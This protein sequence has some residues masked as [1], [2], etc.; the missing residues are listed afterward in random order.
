[1]KKNKLTEQIIKASRAIRRKQLALKIGRS[2]EQMTLERQLKPIVEPLN[3]LLKTEWSVKQEPKLEENFQKPA[4]KFHSPTKI[5]KSPGKKAQSSP[6]EKQTV[7]AAMNYNP[8]TNDEEDEV[9]VDK[10]FQQFREEY[11]SMIETQPNVVDNFLEQYEVLPRVYVDG[12]LADTTGEYDTTTGPHFDP[13]ENKLK[14]GNAIL[15]IDGKDIVI[16]GIRYKGTPGLYELIFKIQP[17]GYSRSDEQRYQDI[18]KRTSVHHRNYDSKQRVKASRSHKYVHIIKPLT[19][20]SKS[21]TASG[22]KTTGAGIGNKMLVST[23]PYQFVYWDDIN[24]LVN[25]LRLLLAS[26]QAGNTSHTNEI[27][28]IV[29]ELK[30]AGVIY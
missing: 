22:S 13:I 15:Q 8:L 5:M 9:N 6:K 30:E 3:K 23:L 17:T 4:F 18:L 19:Y 25:R 14:L 11:Q 7:P 1:M 10:S 24:E 21:A 20:R 12:L 29:E 26:E 2:E 28:S 16:D 27:A